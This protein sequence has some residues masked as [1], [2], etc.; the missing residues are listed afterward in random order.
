MLQYRSQTIAR[1]E[2]LRAIHV[3]QDAEYRQAIADGHLRADQLEQEWNTAADERVR[4]SHRAM[5]GQKRP[6]GEAFVSGLGNLLLYPGD[7]S[8]P[9]EDVID[10]R[11][12]V[13]TRITQIVV[14]LA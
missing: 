7:P 14:A 13:G 8:A 4:H 6:F 2:A 5:N 11:C 10:C 9:A 1:S 3:G 12:A